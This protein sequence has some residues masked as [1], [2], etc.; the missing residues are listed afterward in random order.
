[1]TSE[2]DD[3]LL[4]ALGVKLPETKPRSREVGAGQKPPRRSAPRFTG[5]NNLVE[6]KFAG[7]VAKICR[8]TCECCETKTEIL[9]GVFS[10]ETRGT[11]RRMQVLA[12][13][14]QWPVNEEH[15]FE[16][17]DFKQEYC[18]QCIR[19]LGFAREEK[20]EP[21]VMQ[22]VIAPEIGQKED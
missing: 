3:D 8:Y 12:K 21:G 22:L 6:F 1:M 18:A 20:K 2:F 9:L 19:D 11:A 15:S 7:Y 5:W 4:A 13:G 17:E 10:V 14:A 16:V